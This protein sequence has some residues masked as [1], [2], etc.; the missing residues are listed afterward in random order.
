[1]KRI[2]ILVL[3]PLFFLIPVLIFGTNETDTGDEEEQLPLNAVILESDSN[4]DGLIDYILIVDGQNLKFAE[5]LD[6]DYDGIMDD[7][8]Y[9]K[10]GIMIRREID[11]NYDGE[12]D[13]WVY[14]KEGVYIEMYKRD[15]DFDGKIDLVKEF[16]N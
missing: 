13:I 16:G 2:L 4:D 9:Y 14:I 12:I 5:K 1:M 15:L 11:S 8:Y 6:F 3:L 10:K 7:F